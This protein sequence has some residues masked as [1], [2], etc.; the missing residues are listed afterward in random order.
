MTIITLHP[1]RVQLMRTTGWRMPENTVKCDRTSRWG[2]P[3]VVGEPVDMKQVRRWG[4]VF[5]P[6]GKLI[7]CKSAKEAAERFGLCLAFDDAIKPFLREQ[8]G[9]KNLAC[10]CAPDGPCHVDHVLRWANP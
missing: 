9:G 1:T 2:N 7:V 3:Y 6:Q 5:S 8:L 4:W 10:W